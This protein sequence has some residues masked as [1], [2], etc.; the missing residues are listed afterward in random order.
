MENLESLYNKL[1]AGNIQVP[2]YIT[3]KQKYG[4]D[5]GISILHSKLIYG[6]IQVPDLQT[7]KSKYLSNS[8][9]QQ[10]PVTPPVTQQTNESETNA[11][12]QQIEIT[13][14]KIE[15]L[16]KNKVDNHITEFVFFLL[17]L[18]IVLYFFHKRK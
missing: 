9:P 7:F 8:T 6:N 2:D 12:A 1:K 11:F 14:T 10:Q 3:F 15:N 5:S 13:P 16:K 17:F 4:N 18:F